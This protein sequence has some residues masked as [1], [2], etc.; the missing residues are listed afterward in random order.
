[1]LAVPF[2]G[3]RSV[4][5]FFRVVR[6]VWWIA[7][8]CLAV[9]WS[10][11][12]DDFVTFSWEEDSLRTARSIELLFDLLVW[13]FAREG[14]KTFGFGPNFG[15]VGINIDLSC[16]DRGFTEFSNTDKRK[17]EL[18]EVVR[19]VLTSG[20]LSSA[21]A[22]KLRGRLEFAD[23]KL[24]GRICKLCLKEVTDHAFSSSSSQL[25]PRL[26]GLLHLFL[27]QLNHGPPRNVCGVS[28]GCF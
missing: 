2:G 27:D 13:Q 23:G 11:F 25:E 6:V 8:K 26:Q 15:V 4:Y 3:S 10:N 9:M 12:Y 18:N 22:L 28:A 5:S 7:C 19:A 20:R 14:D 1:M 24:F 17:L 21:D 16:F